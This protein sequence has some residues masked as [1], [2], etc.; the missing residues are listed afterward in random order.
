MPSKSMMSTTP[1]VS[2][3]TSGMT[4]LQQQAAAA[5]QNRV[6]SSHN[7]YNISDRAAATVPAA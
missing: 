6:V 7:N 5:R 2:S 4:E 1:F 3:S